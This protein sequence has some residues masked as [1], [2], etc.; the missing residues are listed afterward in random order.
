MQKLLS[1]IYCDTEAKRQRTTYGL[2]GGLGGNATCQSNNQATQPH[3]H[4]TLA[5]VTNVHQVLFE[6][7]L[8]REV[9]DV[10]CGGLRPVAVPSD[11]KFPKGWSSSRSLDT[12]AKTV[13]FM[14]LNCS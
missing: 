3:Y 1:T 2:D 13:G 4:C 9:S 7:L 10:D 12:S 8:A 6:R 14:S 5:A 11:A